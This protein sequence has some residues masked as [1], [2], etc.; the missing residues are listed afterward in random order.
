MDVPGKEHAWHHPRT[1][2]ELGEYAGREVLV[3]RARLD[4]ALGPVAG[5]WAHEAL[6]IAAHVPRFGFETDHRTIPHELGLLAP[7]VHLNK[8][9]YRGQETVARVHNL[10]RPPRRMVFLHLDGSD[11]RLPEHGAEIT[12]DG[13]A[14]GFVGSAARHYELGPIALGILKRNTPHDAALLAGGI[15]AA[16]EVVVEA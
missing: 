16:A 6:R 8:G 13:R 14:V 12:L 4:D 9:C 3:P 11:L 1:V 2:E 10:G 5:V 15:P 7:A